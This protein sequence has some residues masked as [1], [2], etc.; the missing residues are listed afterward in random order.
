[1]KKTLIALMLV[2]VTALTL[3]SCEGFFGTQS[4]GG[5][6][7]D[8]KMTRIV[9]ASNDISLTTV[10]VEIY[11]KVGIIP[12]TLDTEPA[13]ECEIVF[14]NTNRAVTAAAKAEL[15]KYLDSKSDADVGYIVYSDGSSI[16]VYWQDDRLMEAAIA[17]FR[18]KYLT[19]TEIFPEAGAVAK[20]GYLT[21]ALEQEVYWLAIENSASADLYNALKTLNSF[22][23]G[24][25]MCEWMANLW[26]GEYGGFY[27]SNSARDNEPFRPDLE[28]TMQ[29]LNWLENNGAIADINAQLPNEIKIQI[30]D[31]ARNMQS[32]ENGYFIHPQWGAFE[33][34]ATDRYGR[35][36]SWA[37]DILKMFTCDRGDGKGDA[38]QY[39]Y[40]CTPS[41]Y[42]CEEHTLNG[43]SCS[44]ATATSSG[45]GISSVVATSA[46]SIT[47]SVQSSVSTAVSRV[48]SSTVTATAVSSRP[49][50]SSSAAFTAWLEQYCS[51]IKDDSGKAHNINALQDEIIAKGFCDEL[52]DFLDK[53][54]AEVWDEQTA[55]GET[56]TGLWQRE[57][58]YKFVWGI[59]KYMPFY[60]N[61]KYGRPIAH[62]EE[63]V[64]ACM[65][66]IMIPA[67]VAAPSIPAMNDLMNQW[68][69]I[70][71]ILS[72]V[73][74][75]HKDQ[76]LVDKIRQNLLDRGADLVNNSIEKLRSYK[77]EDGTFA[78]TTEG[79]SLSTIYSVN[80]SLGL[81]EGD[82]NGN[83]LCSSYYRGMFTALGFSP[84]PLCTSADGEKFL[85]TLAEL[86]PVEKNPL[87]EVETID[88]ESSAYTSRVTLDKKTTDGE[89]I[90]ADD[91]TG[92]YGTSIYFKS[93]I[94]TQYGDY[95]RITSSG[96]GGN[97]NILEFDFL[98]ISTTGDNSSLYQ[99]SCG[100]SFLFTLGV[101]NNK[102][103]IGSMSSTSSSNKTIVTESDGISADEWHRIRFEMYNP[104]DG[105]GKGYAK[106]F[107]DDEL[108]S[109]CEN[110]KGSEGGN[111]YSTDYVRVSFYSRYPYLTE[112]YF[113]N[114]YCN[115][116][117]KDYDPDSTD[118][119]DARDE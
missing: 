96:S 84:V 90:T 62:P 92:T 3:V 112:C 51:T 103:V 98:H 21:K 89:M 55:A 35:D 77:L 43:G 16:A 2:I 66:V 37:V 29:V 113:D 17:A 100:E 68:S 50:Y 39:P 22:Y 61:S 41:G 80:I 73:S 86:E 104:D 75:Q 82:V 33:T 91:P 9:I 57:A 109:I 28:S 69:S 106:I 108:H 53:K 36:L 118:I 6:E 81:R 67:G 19:K 32:P 65:E 111:A 14:G 60:N 58:D 74:S 26:D 63:I 85:K 23:E 97:C 59:L 13:A 7:D 72:N 88:F 116:E 71:S 56:P 5:G 95:L 27:Y 102:V 15:E 49:N 64:N 30:V 52:L 94:G 79:K 10:A 44:F 20:E 12:T 24:S 48:P 87:P 83:G 99:I 119:S 11:N 47:A 105:T 54:Q 42:K 114:I 93:G 110:Y 38:V 1:M 40:Y 4:G 70:T 18:T 25:K 45:T 107:I 117:F 101:K 31:F 46:A 8:K 34:L 78:Y 76:D 115:K